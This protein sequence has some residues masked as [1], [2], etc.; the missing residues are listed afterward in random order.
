MPLEIELKPKRK[1]ARVACAIEPELREALRQY[2]QDNGT[3]ESVAMRYALGILLRPYMKKTK[4][5]LPKSQA[6]IEFEV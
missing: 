6:Q 3:T 2:A 1:T 5:S 4:L